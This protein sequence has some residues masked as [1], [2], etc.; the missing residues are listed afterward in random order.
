MGRLDV[1][2]CVYMQVPNALLAE[3]KSTSAGCSAISISRDGR[4]LAAACGDDKGRFQVC[5]CGWVGV[6]NRGCID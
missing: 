5:V 3:I 6:R 1:Y 4:W 2:T